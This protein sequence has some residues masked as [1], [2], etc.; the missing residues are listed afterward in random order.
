[1]IIIFIIKKIFLEN[2]A[3]SNYNNSDTNHLYF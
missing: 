3:N 1:M 2:N